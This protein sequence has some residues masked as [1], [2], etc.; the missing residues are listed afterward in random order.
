[1]ISSKYDWEEAI[2]ESF[3]GLV[4]E[5]GRRS[6][7]VLGILGVSQLFF[8]EA[9]ASHGFLDMVGVAFR[10]GDLNFLVLN[11][12]ICRLVGCPF[13]PLLVLQPRWSELNA[14]P[15]LSTCEWVPEDFDFS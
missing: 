3:V 10:G 11:G 8:G 9:P 13:E 4:P 1:M 15:T 7:N 14:T 5:L 12:D 6:Q 2:F